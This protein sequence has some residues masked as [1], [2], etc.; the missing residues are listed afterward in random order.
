MKVSTKGRYGLKAMIYIAANS[1]KG[2]VSLRSISEIEGIS[3]NYLEQ[4]IAQLKKYK[5]LK[6]IRGAHGGYMLAKEPKDISVGDILRALE[7]SL[8]PVDCVDE[9]NS[10]DCSCGSNCG[11]DCITKEVWKKIDK[12]ITETVDSI[13]LESLVVQQKCIS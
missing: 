4:L 10:K 1:D 13:S 5:L 12:S 3:E 2:C 6:S 11:I 8:A 7:G 9:K